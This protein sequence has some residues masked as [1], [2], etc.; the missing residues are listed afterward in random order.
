MPKTEKQRDAWVGWCGWLLPN[1]ACAATIIAMA[2]G[3]TV[4]SAHRTNQHAESRALARLTAVADVIRAST[5]QL[6]AETLAE[7]E[8]ADS[9]SDDANPETASTQP[10]SGVVR[11]FAEALGSGSEPI[12]IDRIPQGTAPPAFG[13]R[14]VSLPAVIEGAGETY[15]LSTNPERESILSHATIPGAAA[16][17]ALGVVAVV[18]SRTVRGTAALRRIG[19]ALGD[20]HT[21]TAAPEALRIADRFGPAATSWNELLDRLIA[22][23]QDG[24]LAFPD[25]RDGQCESGYIMPATLDALPT[26][27]MSIDDE[28]RVQFCNGA[29]AALLGSQKADAIGLAV[30]DIELLADVIEPI[31]KALQG[32]HARASLDVNRADGDSQSVIRVTVRSLRSADEA[33]V[34]IMLEDVTQQR[35]AEQA[36]NGFVAQATHE[37]RT[38][39]TNIRLS[40]EEAIDIGDEDPPAVANLLNVVNAEARR[41]ERVVNDMLSVSEIE[42]A[43]L[44]L[45]LD[46]VPLARMFEEIERDYEAQATELGTTLRFTTP[47]KFEP[48][49]ADRD[50][51]ALAVHNVIGNALKYTPPGGTVEVEAELDDRDFRVRV[52]DNGPGVAAEDHEKIFQKFYRTDNARGSTVAGSGL[53]L[54]LARDVA[55]LHG[56]DI[57]IESEPGHGATFTVSVPRSQGEPVSRA[58]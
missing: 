5:D 56:G 8:S 49:Q 9:D 4:W 1:V 47:A 48:I 41:L 52:R 40:A 46:N 27:L 36:R 3:F 12:T 15:W 29:A 33:N 26:G 19:S 37:L 34:L 32:G 55:R 11:T 14:T 42:A 57:T 31:D 53:G 17:L 35:M 50:K 13:G 22:E 28:G 25:R 38:P 54:A 43:T 2:A 51:L 18:S 44:S 21:G 6:P 10:A 20:M 39:L 7:G 45:K 24:G 16:L 58:A 30:R 23:N